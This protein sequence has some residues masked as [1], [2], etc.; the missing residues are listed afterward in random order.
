L[1]IFINAF[2]ENLKYRRLKLS[3][4]DVTE[5]FDVPPAQRVLLAVG[6]ARETVQGDEYFICRVQP[7][8]ATVAE[9][10]RALEALRPA[11]LA[12]NLAEK[13]ASLLASAQ[14]RAAQQRRAAQQ[15]LKSCSDDAPG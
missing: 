6:F 5:Y 9:L 14:Q 3:V 10:Q 7:H 13:C 12:A 2:P 11:H 15:V 1:L 4:P 8:F